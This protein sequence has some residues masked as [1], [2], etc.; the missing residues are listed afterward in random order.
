MGQLQG[1]PRCL[2]SLVFRH[3]TRKAKKRS[4]DVSWAENYYP[5]SGTRKTRLLGPSHLSQASAVEQVSVGMNK[6]ALKSNTSYQSAL[7]MCQAL[8]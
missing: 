6:R 1:P 2:T 8:F 5:E 7:T 4:S 3:P